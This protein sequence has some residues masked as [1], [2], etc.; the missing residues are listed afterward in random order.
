ML[1]LTSCCSWCP[2]RIEERIVEVKV[3]VP[4]ACPVPP[5]FELITD[6]VLSLKKDTP[7]E[8]KIKD[9]R[10]SRV[11]WRE[12]AKQLEVLL[13]AYRQSAI[14]SNTKAGIK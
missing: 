8:Q 7:I 4:V 3:P 1:L 13:D 10:V 6:P 9:L 14:D 11:V 2:P 5:S 12:R